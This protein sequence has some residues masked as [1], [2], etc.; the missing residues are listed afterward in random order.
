MGWSSI[1]TYCLLDLDIMDRPFVFPIL[2]FHSLIFAVC[3][4]FL[5][6]SPS[7]FAVYIF[8]TSRVSKGGRGGPV[9]RQYRLCREL[10]VRGRATLHFSCSLGDLG[11]RQL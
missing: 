4:S 1:S 9:R 8:G 10:G 11:K 6:S 3:L 7:S 2:G 5:V